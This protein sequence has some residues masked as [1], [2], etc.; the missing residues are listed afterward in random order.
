MRGFTLIEI[1]IVISIFAALAVIGITSLSS[2]RDTVELNALTEDSASLL[3]DARSRTLSSKEQSQY[4]V[5]FES[6]KMILFQ[7]ASFSSSDPLN[8]ETAIP[9]S[10]EIVD[11][12]LTGG[13]VDIIFERLTGETMQNGTITVRLKSDISRTRTIT[14]ISTG[15]V[16]IE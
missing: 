4:G 15:V 13:G 10:V 14:I 6:D 8:E 5:H 11:I 16:R 7:G 2:F 3:I 9:S 12:L 1:L